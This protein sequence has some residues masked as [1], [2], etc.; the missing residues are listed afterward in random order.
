MPWT[1]PT[2][3]LTHPAVTLVWRQ[4]PYRGEMCCGDAL[5]VET[6]RE[7]GAFFLLLADVMGHGPPAAFTVGF[8]GALLGKPAFENRGP[9][10][11]LTLL[12]GRLQ[13]HWAQTYRHVEAVAVHI[14]ASTIALRG[15]RAGGISDLWLGRPGSGAWSA[16]TVA[17][18]TFLGM[19]HDFPYAENHRPLPIDAWLL[20]VTDG[21]TE[22]GKP[23]RLFGRC[24]SAFLAG[25]TYPLLPT[26]LL[27]LLWQALRGHVGAA[28]P[29][30]DVTALI[31]H[32]DEKN[33]FPP[34]LSSAL[35]KTTPCDE[36]EPP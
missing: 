4:E 19:P 18:H 5:F 13:P 29:D 8:L 22:A 20:A 25:L 12:H 11:L 16:H 21:V 32:R 7:D 26:D 6:G 1:V 34:P 15:C 23:D 28:W 36:G 3:T 9:A 35:A 14:D 2:P 30:D 27:D 17:G 33:Q 24:L 10:E 31:L